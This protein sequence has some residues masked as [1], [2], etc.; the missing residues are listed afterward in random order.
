MKYKPSLTNLDIDSEK[1]RMLLIPSWFSGSLAFVASLLLTFGAILISH[2]QASAIRLDFLDY[3]EGQMLNTY[4]RVNNSL[5]T[6]SI[7]G[8]LPLL[9]FWSLIGLVVYIFVANLFTAIYH[10]AE[11]KDELEYV[12]V[13]RKNLIKAAV[14]HLLIR[15]GVLIVW[16]FY[17]LFF[18]HYLFPYS[19]ASALASTAERGLQGIEYGFLSIIVMLL[20]LHLFTVLLRLVL[21]R[22]R[23]FSSVSYED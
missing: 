7:I 12:H 5:S 20:S 14:T 22:P 10:T 17:F 6:N 16:I 8:N 11:L 2:Y 18:I 4:H 15:V 3:Q 21:L 9:L 13:D 19:I 23:I 1:I